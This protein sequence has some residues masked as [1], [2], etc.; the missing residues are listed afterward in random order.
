MFFLDRL[1]LF[2]S[3]LLEIM[4]VSSLSK[5]NQSVDAAA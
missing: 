5:T 4:C 3:M 2:V 1:Q